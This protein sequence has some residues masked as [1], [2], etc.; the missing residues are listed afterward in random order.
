[1]AAKIPVPRSKHVEAKMGHSSGSG[2]GLR[3]T[4]TS[5][6]R[7][8]RSDAVVATANTR[9]AAAQSLV[10]PSKGENPAGPH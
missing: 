8:P 9:S 3:H 5:Y 10:T 7:K 4:I 2:S 6:L 1:M